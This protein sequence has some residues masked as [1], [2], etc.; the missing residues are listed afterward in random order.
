[1]LYK[2]PDADI[3]GF[4]E[5]THTLLRQ[6]VNETVGFL[7]EEKLSDG[8]ISQEDELTE[9]ED[10]LQVIRT[11]FKFVEQ[12][13]QTEG[14]DVEIGAPPVIPDDGHTEYISSAVDATS[15]LK[16]SIGC[17]K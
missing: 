1:V 16:N 17:Y 15:V 10:Y 5:L 9:D 12:L 3:P 2:V 11:V 8:L 13:F 7:L 6:T 14:Q 4:T